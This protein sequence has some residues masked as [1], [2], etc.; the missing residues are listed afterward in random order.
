VVVSGV[1]GV[2]SLALLYRHRVIPARVT[3]ALAVAAVLW[4][5]ALAQYPD[6]LGRSLT[7]QAAAATHEVLLATAISMA[8][9]SAILVP[10]LAWLYTLFQR[11]PAERTG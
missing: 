6:L 11:A 3:A 10:S 4:A 8:V 9:G 7:I 2:G 5:W 1:A